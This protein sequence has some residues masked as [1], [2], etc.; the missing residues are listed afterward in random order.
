MCFCVSINYGKLLA[1]FF[2]NIFSTHVFFLFAP[3]DSLREN[4]S[5]F[6]SEES[7]LRIIYNFSSCTF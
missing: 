7:I 5:T 6:S 2:F 1:L 3:D 4:N